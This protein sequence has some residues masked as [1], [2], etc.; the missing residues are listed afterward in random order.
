MNKNLTPIK[1]LYKES[2]T[3]ETT[4]LPTWNAD[5]WSETYSSEIQGD[6]DLYFTRNYS[7]FLF[8]S[9]LAEIME[10][11]YTI[12][13][14]LADFKHAVLSIFYKNNKKY[15]ELYRI[16][17][18]EDDEAYTLT[19][20]YDMHETYTGTNATQ[21]S[22]ITGQRTDKTIDETGEQ[23]STG[24]DK[25]TGWNSSA[26]NSL[27]SNENAVGNREDTHQF[28][29]GQQQDTSRTQGQDSH[30]LRRYGNIG[31]QT[32]DDMIKKHRDFWVSWEFLQIIFDDICKELLLIGR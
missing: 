25:V 13:E 2:V 7:N 4:L 16:H 1:E 26:E 31:V 27:D 15:T 23:H 5:W 20:N 19:N 10:E 12:E 24:L 14:A 28:T 11:D 22:A 8:F 30:T 32:I 3:E 29:K 9:S 18:I 21:G 17:T 6:I